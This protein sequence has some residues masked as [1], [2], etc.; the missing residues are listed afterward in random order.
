MSDHCGRCRYDPKLSVGE[1]ACPFT[2]LYWDFLVRH[3]ERLASNTR[4]RGP[5]VNLARKDPEELQQIRDRAVMLR[6]TL[7]AETFLPEPG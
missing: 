4:M 7:T 6:E 1:K 5:Y 2:T 3:Q